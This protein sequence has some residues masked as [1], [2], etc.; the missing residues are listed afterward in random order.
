MACSPPG[1]AIMS[2]RARGCWPGCAAP[3]PALSPPW[4]PS[5]PWPTDEAPMDETRIRPPPD[6][7]HRIEMTASRYR[8]FIVFL[9]FAITAVNYIDRAA[10]SYAIPAIQRD[11]GLSLAT[12]GAILGAFGLGYA[13]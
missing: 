13:I 4:A 2:S 11:L 5:W 8:W 12:T 3:S 10:L 9:L 7:P 6:S 1:F